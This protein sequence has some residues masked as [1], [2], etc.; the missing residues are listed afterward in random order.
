MLD[1]NNPAHM[2]LLQEI[3]RRFKNKESL[4]NYLVDKTVGGPECLIHICIQRIFL[5]KSDYCTLTFIQQL[6]T[7]EKIIQTQRDVPEDPH[8]PNWPELAVRKVWPMQS[9][10]QEFSIGF[11]MNGMGT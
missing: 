3:N 9:N 11:L 4:Y 6:L 1:E 2:E 7:N 8:I 5:P 10:Y